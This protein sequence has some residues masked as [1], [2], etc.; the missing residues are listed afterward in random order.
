MSWTTTDTNGTGRSGA[1]RAAAILLLALA[2]GG[3]N[4]DG[5]GIFPGDPGGGGPVLPSDFSVGAALHGVS[6]GGAGTVRTWGSNAFGQLGD[7]TTTTSSTPIAVAGITTAV[8]V[9]A[10][11][12]FTLVR[13]ADGTLRAFGDNTHGQLGDG[14]TTASGTPVTVALTNVASFDLSGRAQT[15]IALKADGTAWTWGRNDLGQVGDGTSTDRSTPVEVLAGLGVAAVAAGEFHT[16]AVLDDG[17]V[18]AWGLN[19]SGQLGDGSTTT[20]NT[21][22][23][24]TGISTA[25]AVACGSTFS[26]ALLADGTVRA[27]GDNSSGALGDGTT[28]DSLVPVV[29]TGL[30]GIAK[31]DATS[32]SALALTTAGAVRT[33]GDGSAGQ[34]GNGTN[35]PTQTSTV[36]V[37]GLT[38]AV[39]VDVDGG[40]SAVLLITDEGV[41]YAFGENASSVFGNGGTADSNVPVQVADF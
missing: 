28:T 35:T 37:S 41:R 15:A 38:G 39:V 10:G 3:C 18:R 12:D 14:T 30:S 25:V 31:I 9:E 16:L 7:G 32:D 29:V 8:E 23:T 2:A 22:V 1:I 21:P 34:L 24:V 20:S 40:V 4:R 13:L 27:W 19:T 6:V 26:L 33:W 11:R 36:L 17:T 5:D